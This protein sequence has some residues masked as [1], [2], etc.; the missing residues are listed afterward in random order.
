MNEVQTEIN[1]IDALIEVL[2]SIAKNKKKQK[3]LDTLLTAQHNFQLGMTQLLLRDYE[4]LNELETVKLACFVNSCFHITKNKN[5]DPEIFFSKDIL[6]EAETYRDDYDQV[7]TLP[8]VIKSVLRGQDKNFLTIM[9]YK[10]IYNL[11]NS[12]IL[13]YNYDTQRIAKAKLSTAGEL[14]KTP[15]VYKKSVQKIYELMKEENYPS[16]TILLNILDN[17]E[18]QIVYEDGELTILEGSQVDLIDGYHRVLA[19]VKLISEYPDFVGFMNIDIKH[20]DLKRARHLLAVTNTTNP[21]DK[22]QR[23]KFANATIGSSIVTELEKLPEFRNKISEKGSISKVLNEYTTFSI[24]TDSIDQIFNPQN[25][26]EKFEI[27]KLLKEFYSYFL[28]YYHDKFKNRVVI[29]EESWFVHHNMFVLF[30]VLAKKMY[31]KYGTE[32][33]LDEIPK[34]L[35]EIEF[36]KNVESPLNSLLVT[37]GKV[38]SNKIRKDLMKFAEENIVV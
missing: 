2:P 15:K 29:L 31:D 22:T 32:L 8:Y 25:A 27:T 13:N 20:F 33:P 28:S 38:N 26:K 10:E 4:K 30:N 3:E 5:I 37:Q 12:N 18:S 9:S 11:Y 24:M 7:A 19:I 35:S 14:I 21:F 6:L 17:G 16:S 36:R 1:V 34:N 23:M